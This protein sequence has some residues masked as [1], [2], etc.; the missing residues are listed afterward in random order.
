MAGFVLPSSVLLLPPISSLN[1]PKLLNFSRSFFL[2]FVNKVKIIDYLKFIIIALGALCLSFVLANLSHDVFSLNFL[3]LL[4]FAVFV[5]P[6]M[7][8]TLP[9]SNFSVSFSDSIIFLTFLT[10]GGEAAILLAAIEM[11]ASCYYLNSKGTLSFGKLMIPTNAS[12]T[13]LATTCAYAALLLLSHITAGLNPAESTR[14]LI[15]VLG[16]LTFSQFIVLSLLA[17]AFHSLVKRKNFWETWKHEGF[18]SSI[19]QIFGAGLA[20]IVYK[21][22][23]YADLLTTAIAFLAFG[24]AYLVYRQSIGEINDAIS[25]AE[26]AEREKAEAER[27]R[28]VQAENYAKQ[29]RVLLEK[30]EKVSDALRISKEA[31]QHSAMHDTLTNLANRANF[32]GV[33]RDLID[34]SDPSAPFFVLFLDICRFKNIN[35][36]LGHTVGDKVLIIVAKR[37]LRLLY[38]HDVVARLGGDEFAIVLKDLSSVED[39]EKIAR[40]IHQKISEP[41]SLSGN[42]IFVELNIGIARFEREYTNPEEI[43]RDADI[44]MHHAKETGAGAAIFDTTL[45]ARF[46]DRIK[47]ESDLR[48]A[49]ERNELSMHYQPLISL[50]DGEIIGFEA[51]LRWQ[52]ATRGF[53]SP[54][55][56]IPIAEDSGLI[57]PITTWI[58]DQT[59]AQIASWRALSPNYAEMIISVNI[60]GK[61]LVHESL[62]DDVQRSLDSVSLPP[63]ALKL[64][65]TESAAME[66]AERTIEIL[67][68][69]KALGVMLSIDDF[70]TGYSSLSHLHR[71]PFDTLKIDRSFVYSVGEN[72]ENS[73][74]LQTIISLAK[75]LKMRVIAEGIE[76]ETQLALLQNL[77]CDFGQGYLMSKPLPVDAMEKLL[78]QKHNWLPQEKTDEAENE[79]SDKPRKDEHL[80]VF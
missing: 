79:S 10:F 70:G 76:T 71:L 36:S 47:L 23:N 11:L 34:K 4:V 80:P 75:N 13:V 49:L 68:R 67:N 77:G 52:H 24:V 27:T 69:L 3:L 30:E 60:S 20:G 50:K 9:R 16:I 35:D 56:F 72:G 58:L 33:L 32:A 66:N 48:F 25:K 7:V 51:L 45:R 15:A 8:L 2:R 18:F 61:H 42:N 12:I 1:F 65:I 41:F 53:I 21:V 37:L 44:A 17:T 40:K 55:D 39:A 5:A 59:C 74:I 62:I 6:K 26:D 78:Y 19:T 38:E 63:T 31:F 57:I 29:L 73:E 14:H 54:A 22:I 64:E 46:L 43:L 28:A